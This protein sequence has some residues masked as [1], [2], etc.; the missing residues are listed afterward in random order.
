[1]PAT[2]DLKKKSWISRWRGWRW[3]GH[4]GRN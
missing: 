2:P 3:R 4:A 1:M